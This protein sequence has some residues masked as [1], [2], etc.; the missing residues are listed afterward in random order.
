MSTDSKGPIEREIN[1]RLE[2]AFQPHRLIVSNDSASH[3]GHS[4]DNGTGESHF[5]V[6]IVSPAFE[7]QNRVARQRLVNRARDALLASGA[8]HALAIKAHAP[9]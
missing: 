4:G 2:E 3:S 9:E 1:R 8:I 5:S 7:G 6:E